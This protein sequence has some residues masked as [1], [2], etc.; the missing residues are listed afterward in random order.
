MVAPVEERDTHV[1]S[2]SARAAV[3]PPKPPPTITT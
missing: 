2:A 3:N 1:L